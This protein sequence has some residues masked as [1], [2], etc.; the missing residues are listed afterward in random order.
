MSIAFLEGAEYDYEAK[1]RPS[2]QDLE[3]R[4]AELTAAL[5]DAQAYNAT[6]VNDLAK[7]QRRV[8]ELESNFAAANE[9]LR[10]AAERVADVEAMYE[11]EATHN[12][13]RM[14]E[15]G[16]LKKRI[17]ELEAE[18]G[19]LQESL[20]GKGRGMWEVIDIKDRALE[21]YAQ[22]VA[23]LKTQLADGRTYAEGC[24]P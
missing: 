5:A 15:I 23:E 1:R 7:V 8:N 21:E 20:D 13:L 18:N 16:G 22:I 9:A 3:Q 12:G 6:L 10:L 19:S 24:K 2:R 11:F 14:I 4:I 17:A